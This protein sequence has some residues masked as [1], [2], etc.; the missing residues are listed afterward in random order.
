MY[1]VWD[2]GGGGPGE[3][4][5]QLKTYVKFDPRMYWGVTFSSQIRHLARIGKK[6]INNWKGSSYVLG[7][8]YI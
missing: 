5:S 3:I 4:F 6:G 8:K 1:S 7:G 2:K